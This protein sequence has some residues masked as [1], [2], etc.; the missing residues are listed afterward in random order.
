MFAAYKMAAT[1][2]TRALHH[3]FEAGVAIMAMAVMLYFLL[4][5]A[6]QAQV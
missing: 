4:V 5:R 2:S 6:A 3:K 1:T